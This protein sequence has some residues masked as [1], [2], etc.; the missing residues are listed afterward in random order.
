MSTPDSTGR[1]LLRRHRRVRPA[2]LAPAA[3]GAPGPSHRS[4]I[5][6]HPEPELA[7]H[8]S[9]RRWGYLACFVGLHVVGLVV[10]WAALDPRSSSQGGVVLALAAV[11]PFAAFALAW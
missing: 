8:R 7:D 3:P 10:L 9:E 5:E 4:R 1:S 6:L 11:G 2:E